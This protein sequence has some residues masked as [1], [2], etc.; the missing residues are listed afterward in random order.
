MSKVKPITRKDREAKA[1][2]ERLRKSG[3]CMSIANSHLQHVVMHGYAYDVRRGWIKLGSD[4]TNMEDGD[5]EFIGVGQMLELMSV[6]IFSDRKPERVMKKHSICIYYDKK[7]WR[8]D[9]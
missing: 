9:V 8:A 3:C 5:N 2:S 7:E 4:L 6:G 1:L